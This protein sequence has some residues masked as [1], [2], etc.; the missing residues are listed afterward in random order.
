[1]GS[2]PLR[3]AGNTDLATDND[4]G[5]DADALISHAVIPTSGTYYV[6]V[7]KGAYWDGTTGSYEVR[8]DVARGIQL[9]SDTGYAND[10]IAG[11]NVLT[12]TPSGTH[13]TATVAGTLMS[14]E[15]GNTDEDHFGWGTINAGNVVEL[16]VRLPSS[17]TLSPSA[18]VTLV[19]SSG[20]VVSDEDGDPRDGHFL[21]TIAADGAYYAKVEGLPWAARSYGGHWYV[22]V[23]W[24]MTWPNAE[25]YAQSLGGHLVTIDD[26][27]EA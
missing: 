24:G 19:D 18:K 20:A 9:E 8:V 2:D 11:A 7:S 12:L 6:V 25:V 27:A 1:M 21:G 22:A 16:D 14:P 4:G 3:N 15:G 13:R 17:S 10:S 23:N 26:A 5:P